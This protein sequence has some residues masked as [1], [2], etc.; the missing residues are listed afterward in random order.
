MDHSPSSLT[1]PLF[2]SVSRRKKKA[3][4]PSIVVSIPAAISILCLFHTHSCDLVRPH[5]TSVAVA[6]A[7]FMLYGTDPFQISSSLLAMLLLLCINHLLFTE[8][9]IV[10]AQG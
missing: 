7:V 9:A 5:P 6:F 3:M 8:V 4:V 1:T 10:S 2:I